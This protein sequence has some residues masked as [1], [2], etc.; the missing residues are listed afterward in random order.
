M[1]TRVYPMPAQY[2]TAP[3]AMPMGVVSNAIQLSSCQ[4]A[5]ACAPQHKLIIMVSVFNAIPMSVQL[6]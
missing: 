6:V 3:D 5:T 4:T 2:Q 1:G